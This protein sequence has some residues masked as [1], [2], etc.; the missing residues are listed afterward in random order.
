MWNQVN[1]IQNYY[2]NVGMSAPYN[3]WSYPLVSCPH[4]ERCKDRSVS[5]HVRDILAF[6]QDKNK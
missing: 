3:Q 1:C 6:N 5:G 4:H 2:V